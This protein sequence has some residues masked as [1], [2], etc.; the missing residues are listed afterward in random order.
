M[1]N[2]LFERGLSI[3]EAE[4]Q[5]CRQHLDEVIGESLDLDVAHARF[6]TSLAASM[7]FSLSI[8]YSRSRAKL[9]GTGA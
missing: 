1:V 9:Y 3:V 4:L 6:N 5:L 2:R 7:I 8:M